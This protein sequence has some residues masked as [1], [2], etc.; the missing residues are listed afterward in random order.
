MSTNDS[1]V[2]QKK[3]TKYN[4]LSQQ[5]IKA[6]QNKANAEAKG[7]SQ[8]QQQGSVATGAEQ[9]IKQQGAVSQNNS[10]IE[11]ANTNGG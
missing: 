11:G 1:Q 3:E 5:Q 4:Q 6:E 9:P 7:K 10:Q 2:L 8:T